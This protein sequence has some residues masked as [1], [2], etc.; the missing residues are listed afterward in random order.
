MQIREQVL[1]GRQKP[2]VCD[3]VKEKNLSKIAT[4]YVNI[5]FTVISLFFNFFIQII[6]ALY[7]YRGVVQ[8]FNLVK[9]QQRTVE[10]KLK[11]VGPS[12]LKQDKVLESFDKKSFIDSID[13]RKVN[14]LFYIT[15][16]LDLLKNKL[17]NFLFIQFKVNN[18]ILIIL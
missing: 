5:Y 9:Q 3:R 1:L 18:I 6:C 11:N 16:L 10:K 12:I 15:F 14:I 7:F 2:S 17:V 13:H 8:L 4:K